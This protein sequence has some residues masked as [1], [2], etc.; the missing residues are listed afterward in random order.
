M[1]VLVLAVKFIVSLFFM[2]SLIVCIYR[3]LPSSPVDVLVSRFDGARP[4]AIKTET[5]NNFGE[6]LFTGQPVLQVLSERLIPTF[7][8]ASFSLCLS[9][10]LGL[11]V[12][13]WLAFRHRFTALSKSDWLTQIILCIP[14]F[15]LA[16]FFLVFSPVSLPFFFTCLVCSLSSFPYLA[17]QI[18][19]KVIQLQN[20]PLNQAALSKGL[21]TSQIY[22]H[23]FLIACLPIL[24]SFLPLWWGLFFGTS[25]II[26]PIFGIRGLG[27]L[28]LE[29]LRN[30]DLP[31]LLAVSILTGVIRLCFSAIRDLFFQ[32]RFNHLIGEMFS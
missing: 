1:K 5:L 14:P 7:L 19:D 25:V 6:S 13:L 16:S 4:M 17:F 15:S 31:V 3:A 28:T 29:S 9:M 26:E 24:L 8:L 22:R 23:H 2:T 30:Q 20:S 11:T 32:I 12:G 18:R 21:T 10:I 27:A